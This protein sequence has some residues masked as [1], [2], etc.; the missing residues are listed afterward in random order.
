MT[1]K[2][3]LKEFDTQQRLFLARRYHSTEWN[4]WLSST[5]DSYALS[6]LEEALPEEKHAFDIFGNPL[7]SYDASL[8]WNNCRAETLKNFKSLLSGDETTKNL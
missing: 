4:K 8:G 6:L 2:E 1:K 3:V 7:P 5:L